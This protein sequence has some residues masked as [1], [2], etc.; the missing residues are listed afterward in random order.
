MSGGSSAPSA[1][2]APTN[3]TVT[4]TNIPDYAQPYVMNMLQAAQSQVFT[5]DMT[6]FNAYQPYSNNPQDYVA[7]FSP[8]QQQAQSSA[9]NLQVPGQYGA[10]SNIAGTSALGALGTTG[11]ANMYGMQGNMAGQQ[12]AGMSNAYGNLGAATGL[13]SGQQAAMY[14][15]Q[16]AQAGQQA[17]GLSNA[18]G[19]LG[20]MAG[21]Q[22]AGQ[23][24]MYGG[25]GANTGQ[26]AAGMSN[27]LGGMGIG[28]GQQ[29][30]QIG[31]SLGQ[32]STNPSAVQSYMNPYI[33]QSLAPQ[34]QLANQQYGMQGAALQGQATQQGA[35]GGSRN[36]LMQGLNQQNN[37]LANNQII[38]QGYNTAFNNAQ[39]QMNAA[40]QAALS[41]NAQAQQGISQG[42]AG[43]N[44][45]GQLG[46]AGTAQGLQGAQ[47]AGA[48]SMQ[49][50]GMG[51][52]GAAQA[53]QLGL[54][55]ANAGLAGAQ[56]QGQLG[57]QGTAQ[58]LQ[59][60]QQAG[61]LGM[62][63]AQAG[64][65]GV[66]AQQAGYAQAGTQASNLANI[67]GQDLAA[68]QGIINTQ[69]TQG[70]QQQTQ[71]QN[72][73][74]QA[75]QNYATAQQYPFMQ[76]GQLNAM[77]RGLPMQ[78]S[79][80]ASYQ[81]QPTAVQS[82]I[83]LLGAGAALAGATK[84]E[85]GII[86][87]KSGGEVP[88]FKY[89]T[90]IN[91]AQL[92]NDA[93]HLSSKQIGDRIKDP[94]VNPDE[95]TM[96]QGV[97]ADQNRLRQ[98]PAAGPAIAQ[99]GLPQQPQPGMAPPP[100]N[101][102]QMPMDARLSGIAQGGG[103]AFQGMG[104][105]VRMAGGGILAFA[106]DGEEGSQVQDPNA[107]APGS[108]EAYLAEQANYFKSRGIEPGVGAKSKSAM[109]A[110]EAQQ[111]AEPDKSDFQKRLA[112]AQG[113]LDFAQ[114][115]ATGTGLAGLLKPA[116]HAVGVGA[117]GYAQAVD[118]ADKAKL[119]NAN[120]QAALEESNRKAA[121]GDWQGATKSY[122][123]AEKLKKD[124]DIEQMRAA[125]A[126]KVA[127]IHASVAGASTKAEEKVIQSYMDQYGLS[128]ADAYA[129]M[130]QAKGGVG[131]KLDLATQSKIDTAVDKA[132]GML[133]LQLQTEKDP[134]KRK[135]LEKQIEDIAAPI[136]ARY[137]KQAVVGNAPAPAQ[138][139]S[140]IMDGHVFPDQ[141]SL[142]AYK[143]AKQKQNG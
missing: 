38:S 43:A 30:A 100:Q 72:V 73:I 31:A 3:T 20:S 86:G 116:A 132:T 119:A 13:Q 40:N 97:Q 83:G 67:G 98:N 60:A 24:S 27:M 26:Q 91:D 81:A 134:E 87:M 127:N 117:T 96:F 112:I 65:A 136:R 37:M 137:Q 4:N 133:Q 102:Q 85:G 75:V 113:F 29:G 54:S 21:Q 110:L 143:A 114:T 120:A 109:S 125:S 49:G 1:S 62:Q 89:G 107:P 80:T 68:Q 51:L 88:G 34:L 19:G 22:A 8:L 111:K 93:M 139:S 130:Q 138:Q 128:Y 15:Q 69:S 57:M 140:L 35:F 32:Q 64:L 90:L 48:Q 77:L 142:D 82:G 6:G 11:Q 123:E 101:P 41:G 53:G 122:E 63:G 94:M 66:G 9:A 126:E 39:N 99:A 46:L 95:R 115:P 16:G 12:A 121:E 118:S 2:A 56:A 44:Q 78:Q 135:S 70:A 104:S 108:K 5:P 28:Q 59:G 129:K 124:R 131:E 17:A 74:N 47:Q 103:G 141:K 61:S 10:A 84:K 58:G 92:Q 71:Q 7:S 106:G 42:L 45:A 14:G 52:S 105:P 18:Y 76:L 50:Y 33:Q 23:S 36:A 79:S 55:G 25:M